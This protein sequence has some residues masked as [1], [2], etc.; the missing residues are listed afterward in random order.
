MVNFVS[1]SLTMELPLSLLTE[2]MLQPVQQI[3]PDGRDGPP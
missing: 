3:G 2:S 1:A